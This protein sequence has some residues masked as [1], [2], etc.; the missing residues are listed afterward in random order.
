M[1]RFILLLCKIIG[2]GYQAQCY[3]D[4][5]LNLSKHFCRN[6]CLLEKYLIFTAGLNGQIFL[7]VIWQ[8]KKK[9]SASVFTC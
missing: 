5:L 8:S 9:H 2:R 3:F 6:F 1:Y 7:E 4:K